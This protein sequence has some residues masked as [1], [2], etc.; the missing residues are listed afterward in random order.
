MPST[1]EWRFIEI[2]RLVLITR[3]KYENKVATVVDVV[4]QNRVL[5]DSP[6][7]DSAWTGIPRHVVTLRDCEATPVATSIQRGLKAGKLTKVCSVSNYYFSRYCWSRLSANNNNNSNRQSRSRTPSE[8]GRS[9]SGQRRFSSVTRVP[10][11]T[12]LTDSVLT[13]LVVLEPSPSVKRF[14]L[15]ICVT[16]LKL[17]CKKTNKNQQLADKLTKAGKKE[18]A[19]KVFKA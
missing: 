18:K 3:G 6:P 16:R 13:R 9:S 1:N 10:T 5:V 4:D 14:V 7:A 17:N 11:S 12:T 15:L 8:D 2:G 19:A